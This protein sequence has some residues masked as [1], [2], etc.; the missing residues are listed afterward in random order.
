MQTNDWIEIITLNHI[1]VWTV[2]IIW[3][4]VFLTSVNIQT[5]VS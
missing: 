2:D 4:Q 1:T 3:L 5:L